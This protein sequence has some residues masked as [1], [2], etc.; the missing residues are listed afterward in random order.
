MTKVSRA[1]VA[2]DHCRSC[3]LK[4]I[5]DSTRCHRCT[6]LDLECS[7]TLK[8]S[9][10]KRKNLS[11][12]YYVSKPESD[13]SGIKVIQKPSDKKPKPRIQKVSVPEP[14]TSTS[15]L[16]ILPPKPIILEIVEIYFEN[17]YKSIFPFLHK[18]SF[19]SFVRSPEFDPKSYIQDYDTKFFQAS[20]HR[21]IKY[22]DPIVILAIFAL[23][24][25]LHP[26]MPTIYGDFT[27]HNSPHLFRPKE[28]TPE[29]L[30]SIAPDTNDTPHHI[31]RASQASNYFGW[32]ARN[33]LKNVFDSPT[34]QRVQA[35]CMLSSHE[36]GEG[37]NSRSYLYVGIAA[38]MALVLGLGN[39]SELDN[40]ADCKG[41][42]EYT[43]FISI[44][45]KRRTIWSVYM[46]DRCNSSG[47]NRSSC[48][49][50]EDI[51]VRLPC[52][53]KSFLFGN[54]KQSSLTFQEANEII[55]NEQNHDKLAELSCFGFLIILFELWAKIAKWVGETG[56]K[57]ESLPPHNPD[58]TYY[59]LSEELNIF[60]HS[61]PS[62]LHYNRFNLEAHIADGS[63]ADFGYF[64]CLFSLCRIFLNR[65]YFFCSPD[66]LPEGWWKACT[67]EL[68]QT[69][70]NMFEIIKTLRGIDKMV[71]APFTGFEVFTTAITCFYLQ[72][73]PSN[74]LVDYN[75]WKEEDESEK[76]DVP[77][78]RH[79]EK[80]QKMGQDALELLS[81]WKR[82]WNLG[83]GWYFTAIKL[84][85]LFNPEI[86]KEAAAIQ[87]EHIRHTLHDYGSGK[88]TEVYRPEYTRKKEMNILN[89]LT[90]EDDE[91]D[92][93]KSYK[94]EDSYQ[95][96]H[97]P[98]EVG[99][100]QDNKGVVS[101]FV[102]SPGLDFMNNFD[103]SS[104]FPGWS[105][106]MK[107]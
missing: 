30:S 51:K 74:V 6:L 68:F 63:A 42:D 76:P 22:P 66:S 1:S 60:K 24:A 40:D 20:Y 94:K 78:I 27:E 12:K 44:E 59:K 65:E 38:R 34:I 96:I 79:R 77:I 72:T 100:K 23:T 87:D 53:E 101:T 29:N 4:C 69:I 9:Q 105:D 19:L 47:R 89:L 14:P 39:E 86:P 32:H 98:N 18:P 11:T 43:Q 67:K 48:I 57:L 16:I 13:F 106:A 95:D 8:N 26:L 35:L 90:N 3:K 33:Y 104:I 45:S 61:L 2:C 84:Q 91:D 5:N 25:R 99:S 50:L 17:Q 46:M 81:Y 28:W 21:S 71:L 31:S 70:D 64:H 85:G 103:L 52:Q 92:E 82:L 7:Y 88:V 15:P 55:H 56:G 37:N 49:R 97:V 54:F 36:W 80:Y 75:P 73:F 107:I 58:S 62:N 10:L 41:I 93:E 83:R 102:N